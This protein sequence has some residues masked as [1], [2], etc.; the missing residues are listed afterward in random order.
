MTTDQQVTQFDAIL[1]RTQAHIRAYIAGMGI[2]G[3][4]V[5]DLA[6]D[7]YVELYRNFAKMPA[8]VAPERWLKGIARN[9][10]LNHIRVAARK[11]RLHQKALAE[12]LERTRTRME[13]WV[14]EGEIFTALDDCMASLSQD[15]RQII[16]MRY[17]DSHTSSEIACAL[18]KSDGSIR[19]T[20][21]RIRTAL[22]D[23]ISKKLGR[24][25]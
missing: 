13:S 19:V 14:A 6:Q 11:G 10:C 12:I 24:A 2:A 7:V 9:V 16:E 4:E 22:R 18:K 5:D 8:G 17:R 15:L 20:L 23:C 25:R 21:H 3:H 1:G